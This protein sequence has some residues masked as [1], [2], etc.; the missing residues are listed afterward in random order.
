MVG[1]VERQSLEIAAPISEVIVEIPVGIGDRV[2]ADQVVVRL[3]SAVAEAELA[4]SEAALAAAEAQ[5]AQAQRE[6]TRIEGLQRARVSSRQELDRAQRARDEAV[7]L[8]AERTARVVQTQKRLADLTLRS[9]GGGMVDE[10]PFE[11]GERTSA[12]S[13]VAVVLA[14]QAP[15]V[16][17]WLPARVASKVELG[18]RARVEVEGIDGTL[19]GV[20]EKIARESDFTPH[21]ALT[22]RESAHLVYE[23][24]IRLQDAP[25]GLRPGLPARVEVTASASPNGASHPAP[26]PGGTGSPE[27]APP[28]ED[29]P[30]ARTAPDE[31]AD[32][33][34]AE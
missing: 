24:R 3:D 31:A 23:T 21:F 9:W 15:Y 5:Q 25:R 32:R 18:N 19:A 28:V 14:D 7:A 12:G 33:A 16:R 11:V 26:A 8:V 1:T 27:T 20:V 29:P 2:A 13:V 22:E 4:A 34:E 30:V 6:F 10:L 17:V